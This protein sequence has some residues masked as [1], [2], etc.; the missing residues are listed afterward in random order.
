MFILHRASLGSCSCL[1]AVVCCLA[2]ALR[3]H[4]CAGQAAGLWS[5]L[6]CWSWCGEEVLVLDSGHCPWFIVGLMNRVEWVLLVK[7]VEWIAVA[8][9]NGGPE[10]RL[11]S[12]VQPKPVNCLLSKRNWD[13]FLSVGLDWLAGPSERQSWNGCWKC[14]WTGPTAH[15]NLPTV[16]CFSSVP[17]GFCIPLGINHSKSLFYR[18]LPICRVLL[19]SIGHGSWANYPCR[20]G[21]WCL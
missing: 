4:V 6:S 17:P 10:L 1:W 15:L 3:D 13:L 7:A 18:C 12:L 16:P 21:F 9:G 19:T 11:L 14:Y 5:C 8:H 20:K 2:P